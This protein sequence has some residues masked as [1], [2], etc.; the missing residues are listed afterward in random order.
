VADLVLECVR[1]DR[2]NRLPS[3]EQ[4]LRVAARLAPAN[5]TAR[6]AGII[7]AENLRGVIVNPSEEGVRV[8]PEGV[9][10]GG[11]IGEAGA[12]WEIGSEPPDGT[13]V[14][15]RYSQTGV[16]LL[17]DIV[18]SR[19]LW[20]AH[21]DERLL[22]S[23]S[24]RAI[25]ALL[26]D[27]RLERSAVS[28]LLASGSLGPE[29]SWDARVRRLPPDSRLSFDR[30]AWRATL[31]V[32]PP[33]FEP[34][35]RTER[36]HLD[37]LRDALS[38]CCGK[39]DVSTDRW[40]LPLSGGVDS[41]TILAFMVKTG[42]SPKC[43]TWTTRESVRNPLSDASIARRLARKFRVE[44]KYEFLNGGETTISAALQLFVE[45]GE[46][47]TDEFAAYIDGCAVWRNLF[48]AGTSGIIRGDNPLGAIRRAVS[49]DVARI[50]E[51]GL[52]VTDYPESH[53]VRRLGLTD[54][55][56]PERL[57]PQPGEQ[58]EP[59]LDRLEQTGWGPGLLAP[60]NAIK[61]RYLEVVNPLLSRRIVD[62]VRTFPDAL[63]GHGRAFSAIADKESWPIPHA[64]WSSTP[65]VSDYLAD[66]AIVA[67]VVTELTSAAVERVLSEEAAMTLLVTLASPSH[68]PATVHDRV[69]AALKAIS[70]VLPS[71][72]ANRLTP[73]YSGPDDPLS[74]M[75]VAFRATLASRTVTLLLDD[76]KTLQRVDA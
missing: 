36:E 53:V 22:V 37:L 43:V 62:L 64:R 13:Y 55:E 48:A 54:Q 60:L 65:D 14:L 70:V 51:G 52:L 46:G 45:V 19:P 34:V 31:E 8:V 7:E 30:D 28:W 71:R 3:S 15:V 67:A 41:R 33:R 32:R 6:P 47:C 11:V 68:N 26:G 17:T 57:R 38:W 1:R 29:V 2:S 9:L 4:F 58:V 42:R 12:W 56:W 63:R 49:F 20:Y 24:Q 59:Y 73:P 21:D 44:H 39:L 72:V 27:F 40:L 35:V 23:T 75:G 66:Q 69:V 76:A 10:L 74:A 25:V 61:G 5:I 16:E 50:Q 18:A